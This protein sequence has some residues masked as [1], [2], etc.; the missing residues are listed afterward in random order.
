M[1]KPK[2]TQKFVRKNYMNISDF[3]ASQITLHEHQC[4]AIEKID[5]YSNIISL[6]NDEK[7]K[8]IKN[9]LK[10]DSWPEICFSEVIRLSCVT[11][12]T[13]N[14]LFPEN[15]RNYDDPEVLDGLVY[16]YLENR[17]NWFSN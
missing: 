16:R 4:N 13:M 11:S 15:N 6:S 5:Y 12:D 2:Y 17:K 7:I 1:N 9:T 10:E 8:L 14:Y 3:V